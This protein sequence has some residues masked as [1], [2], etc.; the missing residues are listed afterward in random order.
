MSDLEQ[1][2]AETLAAKWL[3]NK[4]RNLYKSF[5]NAKD[6]CPDIIGKNFVTILSRYPVEIIDAVCDPTN[7]IPA[8]QTFVPSPKELR[9]ACE[10]RYAPI[11]RARER[12][13]SLARQMERRR[14]DEAAAQAPK[15]GS[16]KRYLAD[17]KQ[18]E[19][20]L[21]GPPM[22]AEGLLRV[23][24]E[25]RAKFGNKVT[26]SPDARAIIEAAGLEI[27]G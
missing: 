23:Y 2:E 11:L 14:E 24:V 17:R 21:R 3:N 12:E 19:R 7:G 5:A 4:A 16:V 10:K 9:D 8:D 15:T 22:S 18:E 20:D 1:L 27:P 13:E 25:G 26:L 6:E